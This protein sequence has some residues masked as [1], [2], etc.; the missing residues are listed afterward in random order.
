ML[1][2]NE[3]KYFKALLI[4]Q[5]RFWDCQR[6]RTGQLEFLLKDL[7]IEKLLKS[8]VKERRLKIPQIRFYKLSKRGLR[9][10]WKS[11]K[12]LRRF[13]I[14]LWISKWPET[15]RKRPS[16][17]LRGSEILRIESRKIIKSNFNKSKIKCYKRLIQRFSFI[18]Q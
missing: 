1:L 4:L 8:Q 13:R 9:S 12:E 5:I 16:M 10:F 2:R 6:A 18:S 17:L 15:M 3:G 7:L 14:R 11:L